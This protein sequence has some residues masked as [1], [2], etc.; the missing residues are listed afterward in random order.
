MNTVH[1][2][3]FMSSIWIDMVYDMRPMSNIWIDM[4]YDMRPNINGSLRKPLQKVGHGLVI[5]S[6]RFMLI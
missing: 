1:F 4:V 5:T 2:N 3:I 6:H